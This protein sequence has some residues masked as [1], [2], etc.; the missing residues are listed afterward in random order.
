M[1]VTLS[2]EIL[3]F[4]KKSVNAK[5]DF[6]IKPLQKVYVVFLCFGYHNSRNSFSVIN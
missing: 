2:G 4:E 5:A 3:A 1:T 6:F